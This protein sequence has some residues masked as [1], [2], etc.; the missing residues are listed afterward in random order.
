MIPAPNGGGWFLIPL[1]P[2]RFAPA[3]LAKVRVVDGEIVQAQA[4]ERW[5]NAPELP[6][7]RMH[8]VT[9]LGSWVEV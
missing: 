9:G 5:P 1:P 3:K 2:T 4:R 6:A 8:W 7:R